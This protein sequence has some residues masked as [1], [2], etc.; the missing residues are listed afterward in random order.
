MTGNKK[1]DL[2]VLALTTAVT[3]AVLGVF[4]Y[5]EMLFEK[6]PTEEKVEK[7]KLLLFAKKKVNNDNFKVDKVII[8]L[9]TEGSRLRFLEI[10]M[11]LVP[12]KV[13]YNDVFE[14][15]KAYIVDAIIDVASNMMPEEL[16]SVAGKIILQDRIRRRLNQYYE[17]DLVKEIFFSRFV[18]Q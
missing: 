12:F 1:L 3:A 18:V 2:I 9:T 15:S 6:P 13:K 14:Q 10:E 5:T 7:E 8:N 4:V 11:F 16:N 17:K